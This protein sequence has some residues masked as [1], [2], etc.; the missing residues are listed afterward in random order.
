MG[1]VAVRAAKAVDYVGAGT[2]EFLLDAYQNFYFLEMNTRLQVEHPITEMITG[3]DLVR[4]QLRIASGERLGFTQA[5]VER[6][7]AA[8]ECRIYAEDSDNKFMPCPGPIV[9]ML[10]PAGPGVREDSGVYA[11]AQVTVHY[12]PMI[13]KLVVWGEDRKHAIERMR[14]ALS[15]YVISGIKTNV[16]FHDEVLGHPAFV[17]GD[18]DTEFVPN[19]LRERESK[20]PAHAQMAELAAVLSAFMRD[21]ALEGGLE[22]GPSAGAASSGSG[23]PLDRWKWN[24]RARQLRRH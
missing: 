13:A 24:G 11:G 5:E 6:R 4:W 18:Y 23:Q 2:V 8:I 10:S 3:L 7:G 19:L 9:E 21:V 15:E 14:R 1:E 16:A 20:A 17:A 22:P 12:D